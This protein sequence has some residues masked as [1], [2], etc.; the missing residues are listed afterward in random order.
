MLSFSPLLYA[1]MVVNLT[2][3]QV[4]SDDRT[5]NKNFD[6]TQL[7]SVYPFDATVFLQMTVFF[8]R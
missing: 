1:S 6:G 7:N 3:Y 2:D 5:Q 4:E 8:C